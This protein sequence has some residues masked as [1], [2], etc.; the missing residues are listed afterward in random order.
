LRIGD[1]GFGTEIIGS[2]TAKCNEFITQLIIIVD[3]GCGINVDT[4][5]EVIVACDKLNKYI[6][7]YFHADRAIIGSVFESLRAELAY[8]SG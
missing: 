6:R 2:F 3:I 7:K 4:L 5:G 1:C 8:V